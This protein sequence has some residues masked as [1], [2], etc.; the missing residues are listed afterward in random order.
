MEEKLNKLLSIVAMNCA[1]TITVGTMLLRLSPQEKGKQWNDSKD[2]FMRTLFPV[3][4]E[5]TAVLGKDWEAIA[6]DMEKK[7]TKH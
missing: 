1:A 6:N 5:L 2:S 7:M 3:L 4:K